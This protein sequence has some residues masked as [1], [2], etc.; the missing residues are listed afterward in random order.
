MEFQLMQT[1]TCTLQTWGTTKSGKFPRVQLSQ[2]LQ[3]VGLLVVLAAASTVL[4]LQLSSTPREMCLLA[5]PPT[6]YMCQTLATRGFAQFQWRLLQ[7]IR[8]L[9]ALLGIG[10]DLLPLHISSTLLASK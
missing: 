6:T 3:E 8:W 10:M 5:L 7:L 2:P 4:V 9:E 1:G